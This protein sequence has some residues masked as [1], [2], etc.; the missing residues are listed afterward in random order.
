MQEIKTPKQKLID[1]VYKLLP[2]YEGKL[3]GTE[4]RLPEAEAYRNFQTNINMAVNSMLGVVRLTGQKEY[5]EDVILILM[6]LK[7]VGIGN[8]EIVRKSIFKCVK[9]IERLGDDYGNN[10]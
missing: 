6:G 8:R 5:I 1:R 4:E 7:S 10:I 3:L 2:I 9:L